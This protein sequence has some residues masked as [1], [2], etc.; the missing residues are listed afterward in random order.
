MQ[1]VPLFLTI[2]SLPQI[3]QAQSEK[4]TC[5]E[6]KQMVRPYGT[7]ELRVDC[8][9]FKGQKRVSEYKGDALHGF[10]QG[11]RLPSGT[12]K[13]SCFYRNDEKHGTCL[14]WDTLGNVVNRTTYRAG[15]QIGKMERYYAGGRPRLIKHFND[16]GEEEGSWEEWWPNGNKKAEFM[17][18][19]GRIVSG[20]EY[21][22]TGKPRVRYVA[23]YE[24][25]VRSVL[26]TKFIEAEAWSP[27]G[28]SSGKIIGGD[29][30]WTH[31]SAEPDSGTGRY[32]VFREVYKDSLMIKG[33]ALDSAEQEKW[34]K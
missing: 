18:K 33:E 13:D 5:G 20:T 25:E 17:A 10:S 29:G 16:K 15:K 12:K 28:R 26:K 32:N 30:E 8:E 19:C 3:L 11:F 6:K 23:K 22:P 27:I 24:P 1:W 21:Y 9:R 14:G 34:L 31:F 4:F 7:V 2:I